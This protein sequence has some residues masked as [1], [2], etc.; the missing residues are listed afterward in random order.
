MFRIVFCI[1]M[2]FL[3]CASSVTCAK[4]DEPAVST[5]GISI[6]SNAVEK[7]KPSK[8]DKNEQKLRKNRSSKYIKHKKELQ[9]QDYKRNLKQKELEYLEKRLE[10]KKS[11]LNS[12]T[13]D[14]EKGEK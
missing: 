4:E 6:D 10:K 8:Q 5:Q 12:L 3:I 11:K 13:A 9:K 14:Q 7:S 1:V 2:L